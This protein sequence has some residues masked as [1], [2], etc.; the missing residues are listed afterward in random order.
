MYYKY[1]ARP[2]FFFFQTKVITL[3]IGTSYKSLLV[4]VTVT[5]ARPNILYVCNYVH[6]F[7][8]LHSYYVYIYIFMYTFASLHS[9]DTYI[10]IY[11]YTC[12]CIYIIYTYFTHVYTF[13][14]TRCKWSGFI[15]FGMISISPAQAALR[16]WHGGPR[17]TDSA[18]VTF[19]A[20]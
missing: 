15:S 3:L 19:K 17:N 16:C 18:T 13:I 4:T 6:M 20:R 12:T 9:Y 14:C 8:V 7:K 10:Y 1:L 11:I 5:G 2:P